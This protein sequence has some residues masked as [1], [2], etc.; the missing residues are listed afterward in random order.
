MSAPR[1]L[2]FGRFIVK[3]QRLHDDIPALFPQDNERVADLQEVVEST[4]YTARAAREGHEGFTDDTPRSLKDDLEGAI[5]EIHREHS[6]RQV[7][8]NPPHC[9][10]AGP[11]VS[12]NNN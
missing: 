6:R 8:V 2:A 1:D 12:N 10:Y 3:L 11:R 5:Q 9:P 7:L 4:I